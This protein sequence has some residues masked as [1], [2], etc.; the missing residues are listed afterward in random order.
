[1]DEIFFDDDNSELSDK[2]LNDEGEDMEDEV[3]LQSSVKSLTQTKQI[4]EDYEK[5]FMTTE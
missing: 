2:D 5:E 4:C 1:V 3:S